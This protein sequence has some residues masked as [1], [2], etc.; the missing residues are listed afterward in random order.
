ML[1]ITQLF[2]PVVVIAEIDVTAVFLVPIDVLSFDWTG[3]PV[4]NV[5]AVYVANGNYA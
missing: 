2:I 3:V 4:N 1:K 5:Y